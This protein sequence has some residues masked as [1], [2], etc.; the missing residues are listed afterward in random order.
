[1]KAREIVVRD[2]EI[3]KLFK[4][5]KTMEEIGNIVG[6]SKANVSYRLKE[7]EIDRSEGGVA[8][9]VKSQK[10]LDKKR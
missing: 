9:R 6:M 7:M 8:K 4:S 5:G 1:M 10:K 3:A 2:K